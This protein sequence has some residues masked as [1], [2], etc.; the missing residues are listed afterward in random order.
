MQIV[1]DIPKKDYDRMCKG[2]LVDTILVAI[3]NGTLIPEGAT[4]GDIIKAMFPNTKIDEC[5]KDIY[6][7]PQLYCVEGMDEWT[8][9][10]ANWWNSP[11]EKESE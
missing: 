3:K 7:E 4:N 5:Q 6:E 11:Y 2:E 8:P 9:F 1:I 10:R